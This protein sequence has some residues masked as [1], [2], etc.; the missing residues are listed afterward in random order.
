LGPKGFRAAVQP[1]CSM[2]PPGDGAVSQGGRPKKPHRATRP[3]RPT[4]NVKQAR[5]M[6]ATIPLDLL[7]KRSAVG[8][9]ARKRREELVAQYG[10]DVSPAQG[11]LIES[12]VKTE[13]IVRGAEDYIL[14]QQTLVVDGELLPV[15]MQ[16]Q[17]LVDSLARLLNTLGLKRVAKPV[18]DLGSYLAAKVQAPPGNGATAPTDDD[19]AA[20]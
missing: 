17:A 10:G 18:P 5:R 9:A 14:R 6:L 11:I 7:D 1:L 13:L 20:S 15:V 3:K 8:V 2:K 12:A 4:D 16:R 19:E